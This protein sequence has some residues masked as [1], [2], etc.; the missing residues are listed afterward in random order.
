MTDLPITAILPS[1]AKA[2][3]GHANVILAAEPGAGKTTRVPL[4][5]MA[6]TWLQGRKIVMLEPR[7]LAARAAAARMAQSLNE[8]VGAT[9]GYAV[10]LDRK[11]SAQTRIEV[12]T[13][14]ILTRRLQTDPT[15][16]DVGLLIFDEFHERSL[17]GDL[18]LALA[19]DA[20]AALR[21]DL[22]ILVMSATL[23]EVRL[24][25]H[26]GDAPVISAP[27]RTF[28]VETRYGDRPERATLPRD[29]ARAIRSHL[30]EAKGGILAF[31]PGEAE[32]RRTE[33]A[34]K[35]TPL[36]ANAKVM[37][38]YGAMA[39]ADQDQVLKPA[40][41]GTRKIVLATT[42][43][44]TSL[45][46]D[47]IDM[48]I[49]S[50]LKR[51]PRFDPATG[52]T[53]LETIRV[54]QASADQRRGRA[55]RQ[56]P[57]LCIRL[58]PEQEMRALKAHDE[59]EILIADLAPLA[60]ELANW[61]VRDAGSL[62]F[63]DPPPAAAFAQARDLL[64]E[65]DALDGTGT[66]TAMGK[67]MARLPLHPRLAHMIA[68]ARELKAGTM[69]AD[70]AALL[71][72]RDLL[73][74]EAGAD[75]GE[76]L[77][78]LRRGN[79]SKALRERI[80]SAAR[81]IRGIADIRDEEG[82]V[83]PGVLVALAWPD[84]IAQARG[85]RGRFRLS[86]GGGAILPEHDPL[87]REPFLAVATTDGTS[88]DQKIFLAAA[89]AREDLESTFAS[90]IEQ[91]DIVRW[92]SR[93]QIVVAN[94]QR[95]LGALI[96]DD[97][98]L[99]T[100]DPEQIA[101]AMTKG[102]AEMG[103]SSLPW[104]D[105]THSLRN[106]LRF[107]SRVLPDVGWPDLSD[108][109]LLANL[110]DWLTP[111]L[112]GMTRRAHL[113][114]LDMFA[115]ISNLM[116]HELK[117]RLDKLAPRHVAIPSGAEITIDYDGDGD[118]VLRARLQ[119]MFGLADTPRIADGRALLRIEL[120]SPARRPL[121]VTQDLKSFW[122]NAYPQVRSEMRGRYPKHPWPEDPMNTPAVKPNRIR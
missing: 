101:E 75:L 57:G 32:I 80:N 115:I 40:T 20:Q 92:D 35:E 104:S 69:A 36:P 44:E 55:G 60:L 29:M 5:L 122:A 17:D 2:L 62:R 103:L 85:A 96:L 53:A 77:A 74:R 102:I 108:A 16:S 30:G 42:I 100:P 23:D 109:A 118:P 90:H 61:G 58:W 48:V 7:R 31:L 105:A 27:G 25:K 88:G 24:S 37:P 1:L 43:A 112:A 111:Y 56:S 50:G 41:D 94:R 47:G 21:E 18:G 91:A 9:V 98:P 70:L 72:E 13:E 120:L 66:V 76:R 49:D 15:L 99:A 83:A 81:Q 68:R 65:L 11:V 34:L 116:P 12:V 95:K 113:D 19:L 45:T 86:G 6:E 87:A 64:G 97:K 10:R 63:L 117:R 106:R 52:M 3:A 93:A 51:A 73:G 28:P 114:R 22:K 14:G 33:D 26:L 4:A 78:A 84:R 46:I 82:D 38:L 121:A 67:M 8:P 59:P 39:L 79:A 110:S 54:S 89:L 71:S 119:E 107:L